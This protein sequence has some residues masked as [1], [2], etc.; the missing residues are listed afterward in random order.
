[1]YNARQ[2]MNIAHPAQSVEASHV[3]TIGLTASGYLLLERPGLG[4]ESAV[5]YGGQI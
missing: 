2:P 3:V 5:I 4:V 1:M